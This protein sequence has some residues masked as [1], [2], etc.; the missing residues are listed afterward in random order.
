[1]L[2]EG[3]MGEEIAQVGGNSSTLCNPMR[4]ATMDIKGWIFLLTAIWL[5]KDVTGNLFFNLK[6]DFLP[7]GNMALAN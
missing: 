4:S 3:E 2:R 7:G 6:M 1:M 5:Q